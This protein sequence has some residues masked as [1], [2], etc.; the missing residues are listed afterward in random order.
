ML[1]SILLDLYVNVR[2]FSVQGCARILL[3]E[4]TRKERLKKMRKPKIEAQMKVDLAKKVVE[5][6]SKV[7][8]CLRC[9]YLNGL[10]YAL[11]KRLFIFIFIF[12]IFL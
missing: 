2:C 1:L 12:L 4:E 3:N 9:G 11:L 6:C 8:K 5:A 7:V 10:F